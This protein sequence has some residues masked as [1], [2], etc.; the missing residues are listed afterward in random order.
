VA[1]SSE[2]RRL[3]LNGYRQGKSGLLSQSIEGAEAGKLLTAAKHILK[4]PCG[5]ARASVT[6]LYKTM[7]P[8]QLKPIMPEI[9]ESIRK[10]GWSVMFSNNVREKGLVFL[11]ENNISEGLD[12]L[13]KI[14]EPDPGRGNEGYWFAPRVL[15]YFKHY[16]GAARA[17]LPKLREY[18][19]AYKAHRSLK[20]NERFLKEL[21]KILELIEK[22]ATPPKLRSWKTL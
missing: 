16:R 9:I 14:I 8:K 20:K 10:P 18:Q 4:N 2:R 7:T 3:R 12:E 6:T 5:G 21:T 1:R 17:H 15:S 22:D 19:K 13:M 11:A